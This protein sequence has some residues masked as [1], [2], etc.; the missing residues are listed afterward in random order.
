MYLFCCG[1]FVPRRKKR[2][3]EISEWLAG[4]IIWVD[5]V[6]PIHSNNIYFDGM[7]KESTFQ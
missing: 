6:D 2:T 5:T 4:T 3:K 7:I 1:K